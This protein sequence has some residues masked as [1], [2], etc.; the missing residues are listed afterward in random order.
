M[1]CDVVYSGRD[2]TASHSRSLP[3][4]D[5]APPPGYEPRGG[6]K[7]VVL[8]DL[9]PDNAGTSFRTNLLL[10]SSRRWSLG[11]PRND[12][13][14]V[15]ACGCSVLCFSYVKSLTFDLQLRHHGTP[16]K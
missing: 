4:V 16:A 8:W 10:P 12:L 5:Q 14:R 1:L 9:T 7:I 2:Y 15:H 6:L 11:Y 13:F 3:D